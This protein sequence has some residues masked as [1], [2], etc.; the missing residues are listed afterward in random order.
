MKNFTTAL[1]SLVRDENG[2]S[3]LE[4]GLLAGFIA[5]VAM[6]GVKAIGTNLNVLFTRV[7]GSV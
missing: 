5:I 1:G 2:A 3:M 4:Y 7:A 6:V